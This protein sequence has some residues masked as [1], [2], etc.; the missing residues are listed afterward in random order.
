MT[1]N[2]SA[3][4]TQTRTVDPHHTGGEPIGG[5]TDMP[6]SE[7]VVSERGPGRFTEQITI[8]RHV[9]TADE[10]A[11]IGDDAGPDP[12]GLLLAALGACTAMTIRMYADRKGWTLDAVTVDLHHHK[13]HAEDCADCDQRTSLI[14]HIERT[15]HL[16]GGL[17]DAQRARLLTIAE[18][19][20]VHRTLLSGPRIQTTLA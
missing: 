3:T 16:T 1:K 10:P 18:H 2:R 19:C 7:V 15:V 9:L 13:V 14:D 17:S 12:Y 4:R 20:P 11:G 6:A 8:G 5:I